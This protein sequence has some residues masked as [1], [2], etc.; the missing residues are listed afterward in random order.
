MGLDGKAVL[1]TGASRGIGRAIAV[2]MAEAGADVTINCL[3]LDD[4]VNET[5][6]LVRAAGGRCLISCG[7]VAEF[8]AMEGIVDKTIREFGKID[9][10]IANAAYSEREAFLTAKM[11]G[12]RRTVEVTMWGAF[13]LFRA[14]ANR[15][16][17][18]SNSGAMLAISSP[19]AFIPIPGAMAYNMAKAGLEHM[20]RTAALELAPHRIRVNVLCPG[21]T[22]TPGE[23]A[24]RTDAQLTEAA[25]H[26]V[27]GRLATTGEIARVAV[28]LCDPSSE[29]INGST[30]IVDGGQS[31][32]RERL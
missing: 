14:A 2:A 22:D 30:L 6:A 21:W 12:V 8:P 28:F 13:H 3:R 16:I 5:A 15:M 25:S 24:F 20:A 17:E 19:H 7:D 1:V 23:R 31:L 29:Y 10:A 18:K 26:L 32:T 4:E 11:A 27:P 9:I